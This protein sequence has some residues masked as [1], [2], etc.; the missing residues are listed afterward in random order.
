[1]RTLTI[2]LLAALGGLLAAQDYTVTAGSKTYSDIVG[3]NDLTLGDEQLSAEIRPAGFAF[4]YFGRVYTGFKVC[5]NGFLVLGGNGSVT[6]N[7]PCHGTTW[8]GPTIAP[9]WTNAKTG[10]GLA[11]PAADRIAWDFTGDVLTVEWR[12]LETDPNPSATIWDPSALRMKA[13]LNQST[14]VIEFNYG[15]PTNPPNKVILICE[16]I[17]PRDHTVS[18]C[19]ETS[20]I[21]AGSD[22]PYFVS[23]TGQV[24]TYPGGRFIRFTPAAH[25]LTIMT[26]SPLPAANA[27][28]TYSQQFTAVNGVGQRT[29]SAQGLPAGWTMS[30]AGLLSTAAPAAGTWQFT[31]Q[32]TDTAANSASGLFEVQVLPAP[33]VL[34]TPVSPTLTQGTAGATWPGVVFGATGGLTPYAWDINGGT[35]PP[36]LSLDPALG[37]LAGTTTHAGDYHFSVR[38]TDA[39]S[40]TA[41]RWFSLT[42]QAAPRLGAGSSGGGCAAGAGGL[43]LPLVPAVLAWRRRRAT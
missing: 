26:L 39:N 37:T 36:G 25:L 38:V 31:V 6:S 9:F 20:T 12:W 16:C 17:Q 42:V 40:S 4:P 8:P 32:V 27:G 1:M 7:I 34:A 29:W 2:M 3:G 33:L 14:G 23:A 15:D 21:I 30:P 41:E 13:I 18:I 5:D 28:Q 19:D 22:M 43:W 11:N 24:A 35:L 10:T